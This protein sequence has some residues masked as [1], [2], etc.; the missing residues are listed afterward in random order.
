MWAADGRTVYFMSDRSGAENIWSAPVGSGRAAEPRQVTRFREGTGAVAHHLA[1]WPHR[2]VR[3]RL[4]HLDAQHS[5]GRLARGADSTGWRAGGCRRRQ[6]A[7]HQPVPRAGGFARRQEVAFVVRGEVFASNSQQGGTAQR[8]TRTAANESHI[9]WA[10]DSNRVVYV[11]DRTGVP[12]IFLYD[13]ATDREERA[14]HRDSSGPVADV[15]A[16]RQDAGVLPRRQGAARHRPAGQAG[17][18]PDPGHV[19]D[20]DHSARAARCFRRTTSGWPISTPAR[21]CSRTCL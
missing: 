13:F 18:P 12:Q 20:R 5:L 7:A 3:A 1:G 4:R 10:P 8:L 6:P 17:A 14:D 9:V 15:L 2:G 16:G 21:G 19:L 11:S